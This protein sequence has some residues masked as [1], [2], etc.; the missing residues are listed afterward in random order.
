VKVE[1]NAA[2]V[3]VPAHCHSAAPATRVIA[4]GRYRIRQDS[5]VATAC[6]FP[7]LASTIFIASVQIEVSTSLS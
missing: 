7:S 5:P 1:R 4:G 3:W 2:L 6:Y